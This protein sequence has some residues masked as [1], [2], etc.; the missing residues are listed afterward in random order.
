M[1]TA[2]LVAGWLA[3][4]LAGWHSCRLSY[5]RAQPS[6]AKRC[7]SPPTKAKNCQDKT[8]KPVSSRL[9]RLHRLMSAAVISPEASSLNPL[10]PLNPQKGLAKRT[11]VRVL[12]VP[13]PASL[14]RSPIL[15]RPMCVQ[16]SSWSGR[17]GSADNKSW[18]WTTVIK[19]PL[20]C[21]GFGCRRTDG[22]ASPWGQIARLLCLLCRFGTT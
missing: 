15:C 5:C 22:R 8:Q 6:Q 17:S 13:R 20:R 7:L 14:L 3:G 9:D 16:E 19:T 10:S 18:L 12:A 2:C 1:V 11:G 4:W 21:R